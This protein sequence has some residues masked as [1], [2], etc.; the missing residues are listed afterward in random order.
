MATIHVRTII[1]EHGQIASC[2]Q[3]ELTKAENFADAACNII[4]REAKFEPAR[5]ASGKPVRMYST[6]RIRYII[7]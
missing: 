6:N 2:T 5:D 4:L 7:P 3:L 1:D